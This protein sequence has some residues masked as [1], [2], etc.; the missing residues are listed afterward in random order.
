[1][2]TQSRRVV[3]LVAIA[4][5]IAAP[6]VL[7]ACSPPQSQPESVVVHGD[8]PCSV[9]GGYFY[10]WRHQ[11]WSRQMELVDTESVQ[12]RPEPLTKVDVVS[13]LAVDIEPPNVVCEA[14]FDAGTPGEGGTVDRG[15]HEWLFELFFYEDRGTYVI[16]GMQRD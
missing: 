3:C 10:A 5:V 16:T 1:M 2:R 9:V 8:D 6:G 14:T 11:D 12:V 4:L 7:A 13:I 15:R